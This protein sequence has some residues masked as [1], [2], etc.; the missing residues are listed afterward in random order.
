MG[1]IYNNIIETIGIDNII[2]YL[3]LLTPFTIKFINKAFKRKK[4]IKS[5]LG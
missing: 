1:K 2:I 3:T 4:E 5:I